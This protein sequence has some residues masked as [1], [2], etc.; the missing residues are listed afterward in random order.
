MVRR[1][2]HLKSHSLSTNQKQGVVYDPVYDPTKEICAIDTE[3]LSQKVAFRFTSLASKIRKS[4]RSD[5]RTRPFLKEIVDQIDQKFPMKKKEKDA[6][7]SYLR[8][9]GEDWLL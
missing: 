1:E 6:F 7:A 2:V 5:F 4:L 3:A 9:V 8:E